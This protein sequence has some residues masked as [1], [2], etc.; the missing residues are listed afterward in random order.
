MSPMVRE[1]QPVHGRGARSL[2]H[3][4]DLTGNSQAASG[5]GRLVALRRLHRAG[6]ARSGRGRPRR[7]TENTA[8]SAALA[9]AANGGR[10]PAAEAA[11][12]C[13]FVDKSNN[14]TVAASNTA[15]CPTG[16]TSFCSVA[17]SGTVLEWMGL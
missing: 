5:F 16:G 6:L 1:S 8:R 9:A 11:A 7:G 12:R 15:T 4:S 2:K 14:V 3:P 13:G 17:I 10:F